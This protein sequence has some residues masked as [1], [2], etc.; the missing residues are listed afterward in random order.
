MSIKLYLPTFH[1]LL[2]SQNPL[3]K[4]GIEITFT[5]KINPGNIPK[6]EEIINFGHILF[7]ILQT[8]QIYKQAGFGV[9]NTKNQQNKLVMGKRHH[10]IFAL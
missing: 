5:Q 2:K 10:T 3:V 1:F 9:M 6:G 7:K 8:N 4:V